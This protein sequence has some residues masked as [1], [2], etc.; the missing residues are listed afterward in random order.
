MS[1]VTKCYLADTVAGDT[2][3]IWATSWKAAEAQ[4]EFWNFTLLGEYVG[5]LD[6]EDEVAQ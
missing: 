4:C 2:R 1:D 5:T 6:E 3:Y